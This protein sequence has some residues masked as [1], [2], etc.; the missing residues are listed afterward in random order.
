MHGSGSAPL[1]FYASLLRQSV[2]GA[3]GSDAEVIAAALIPG[4]AAPAEPGACATLRDMARRQP[5]ADLAAFIRHAERCG[6]GTRGLLRAADSEARWW[7]AAPLAA[8]DVSR[9]RDVLAMLSTC[10]GHHL[11]AAIGTQPL[12]RALLRSRSLALALGGSG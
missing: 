3:A 6:A 7:E 10:L 11:V 4:G 1:A 2:A 8:G 9:C 12:Q 5:A